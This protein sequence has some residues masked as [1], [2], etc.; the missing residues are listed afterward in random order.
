MPKRKYTDEFLAQYRRSNP[1]L[2]VAEIARRL[3][4]DNSSLNKRFQRIEKAIERSLLILGE[5]TA[6]ELKRGY[7]PEHNWTRTV[8]PGFLAQRVSSYYNKDG[9][10]TGQWVIGKLDPAQMEAIVAQAV[11]SLSAEIPREPPCLAT[12]P[13]T[14]VELA[15]CYI[16][17]DYHIGMYAWGDETGADWDAD[18][19]EELLIGWFAAAIE[20]SPSA[21]IGILAQLGDFLHWDG[22]EAV[23][24]TSRHVLDADTRYQ[25]VVGIAIRV[26]RRVVQMLLHKHNHVHII[27]AEGNHDIASSVWLRMMMEH[28]YEDE[29]RVTVDTNPD[30]YYCY[31]HGKT[32]LFFHHG[33]KKKPEKVDT[34]FAQ[35]FRQVFGRTEHCYAHLGHLHHQ[36]TLE[37]NLMLV[38]QHRTLA[39]PDSHASR[40]GWLSGRSA[41]AITYHREYGEYQRITIT[42]AFVAHLTSNPENPSARP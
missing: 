9:D 19:A 25:R 29:P 10:V 3:G 18:I 4:I 14:S 33:H 28:I 21:E 39:A 38:E 7:A 24:P 13:I 11:A 37:T 8:P 16:L 31:E 20:Q 32:A 23:T 5:P 41:S 34:V 26:I 12:P 42:P 30:P 35:K 17:T 6:N 1:D 22:L 27:M 36:S 40:G 2:N 15:T